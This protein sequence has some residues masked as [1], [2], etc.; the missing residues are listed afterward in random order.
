MASPPK[1]SEDIASVPTSSSGVEPPASAPA[2]GTT[3]GDTQIPFSITAEIGTEPDSDGDGHDSED[4]EDDHFIPGDR[5]DSSSPLR[6]EEDAAHPSKF[7]EEVSLSVFAFLCEAFL[8]I[9]PNLA[10][11]SAAWRTLPDLTTEH[12]RVIAAIL[13]LRKSGLTA[14]HV[15]EVFTRRRITPLR[16]REKLACA[17]VGTN[18]ADRDSPE[19]ATRHR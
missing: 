18:D 6:I 8:G 7:F 14:A 13:N 16:H 4:P 2:A 15:I 11:W 17:Y 10:I 19:A 3:S 9:A 12:E 1:T 5:G